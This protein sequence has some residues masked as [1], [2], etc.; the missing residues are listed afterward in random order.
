MAVELVSD[1]ILNCQEQRIR[2]IVCINM[3]KVDFVDVCAFDEACGD[4]FDI[5]VRAVQDDALDSEA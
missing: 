5:C 2:S 4:I 1:G 3:R